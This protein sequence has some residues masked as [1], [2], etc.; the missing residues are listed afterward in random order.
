[1]PPDATT[2]FPDQPSR[3]L[4]ERAANGDGAA[5]EQLLQQHLPGLRAYLRMKAGAQLLALESSSDLAQSVC[6]D[7]LQHVERFRY[8]GEGAFRKWLFTTAMRKIADRYEYYR[9]D[10]RDVRR[11]ASTGGD[12]AVLD[13]CRGFY[14]PS[15]QAE[16]REELAQLEAAMRELDDDKR[17]VVL[18][19]RI[20]GLSHEAIAREL[21]KTEAAVR[22]TLSRAL[23]EL[24]DRLTP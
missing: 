14:T 18:L 10:K 17:E 24:A 12:D 20:V 7:V 6:R 21:G 22:K 13:A 2:P 19:S 4:V 9:A 23:A 8:D 1:M 16:A 15:R 11:E 5:V 3:V